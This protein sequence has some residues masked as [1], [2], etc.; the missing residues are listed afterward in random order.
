MA[1]PSDEFLLAWS[2]LAGAEQGDGWRTIPIAPAGSCQLGAGRRFPGGEEALL[3]G[4]R[5]ETLPS[6]EKLPEGFGFRVE[7]LEAAT[8]GRTWL[9]IT[10]TASGGLELFTAMVGDICGAMDVE[11]QGGDRGLVRVFLGRVRAWQEF[12]RA[13]GQALTGE[14]EVGLV[15]ELLMLAEIVNAGVPAPQAVESWKGPL[16]GLQDFELGAG[17]VEVKTTASASGFVARIGSLEQLDDGVRQPLFVAGVRL[18][19]GV[20]GQTLAEI[21]D[22]VRGQVSM[23]SAADRLF[24]ERLLKAGFHEC[25]RNAYLRRFTLECVRIHEVTESFPRLTHGR[26]PSGVLRASYDIDLNAVPAV[27]CTIVEV[28]RRLGVL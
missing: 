28:L 19:N 6:A 24:T 26:V 4:F 8:D 20:T 18:R 15:G 3:A 23:D 11:A 9:A 5:S 10:R 13:G 2:S 16:D 14:A 17:A 1:R 12:M 27:S 25:H 7:R 22:A 21:A